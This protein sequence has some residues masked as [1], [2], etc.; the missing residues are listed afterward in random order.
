MIDYIR[1]D[2]SEPLAIGQQN[3]STEKRK[4]LALL[5]EIA[6]GRGHRALRYPRHALLDHNTR[7]R[8]A[9]FHEHATRVIQR[10]AI[11]VRVYE[12]LGVE[13]TVASPECAST[14]G[15][16]LRMTMEYSST[17][18]I[19][20]FTRTVKR[21]ELFLPAMAR[22]FEMDPGRLEHLSVESGRALYGELM[23]RA[24]TMIR[25]HLLPGL[26]PHYSLHVAGAITLQEM[27]WL[28]RLAH[29]I[30]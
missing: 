14:P 19:S 13:F 10:H 22:A 7:V 24:H 25:A 17:C 20:I 15:L 9:P 28:A 30:G 16:A 12:G 26:E 5:R 1:L 8:P 2:Y 27:C 23:A 21:C 29:V 18:E 6:S 4:A 3:P 11:C